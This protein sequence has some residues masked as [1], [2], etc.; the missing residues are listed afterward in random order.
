MG[1]RGPMSIAQCVLYCECKKQTPL[2]RPSVHEYLE[3][4][5]PALHTMLG[6]EAYIGTLQAT[7]QRRNGRPCTLRV[8]AHSP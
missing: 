7:G 6:N 1:I 3:S 2:L 4:L 8:V 5:K